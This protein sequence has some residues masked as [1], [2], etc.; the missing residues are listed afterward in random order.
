MNS[1]FKQVQDDVRYAIANRCTYKEAV[2]IRKAQSLALSVVA[3]CSM[4]VIVFIIYTE[5]FQ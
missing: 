3:A 4:P 5:Y 1:N 2:K